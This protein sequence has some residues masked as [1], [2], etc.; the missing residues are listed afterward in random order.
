MVNK[1][2]RVNI[3][4]QGR[5]YHHGELRPALIAAG[6]AWL[7][8][9][10]GDDIS[11]REVARMVGVSATAVYRHFPDK[12]AF[13]AALCES[14]ETELAQA[15][16]AAAEAAGGGLPGFAASGQAYVRFALANPGLFRL[17]MSISPA[18]G[19]LTDVLDARGPAMR[20]LREGLDEV[21]PGATDPHQ[22][23]AAIHAWS[24]V[25]GMAMLMLDGM[26]P[27]DEALIRSIAAP[28]F[29]EA[30]DRPAYRR[31]MAGSGAG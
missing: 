18:T 8:T 6:L 2:N 21:L 5:R 31:Q 10:P 1:D 17:M 25:H 20:G 16:Q 3:D 11:L 13:I 7:A 12:L 19:R 27:A 29:G 23:V 4:R 22:R 30:S 9:R 15:Q 14:G 26:I 28:Q 24:L